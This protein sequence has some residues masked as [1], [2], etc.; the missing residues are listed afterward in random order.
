MAKYSEAQKRANQKYQNK[1]KETRRKTTIDNY[2]RSA[3]LFIRNHST[4]NDLR[5]L[6]RLISERK[7]ELQDNNMKHLD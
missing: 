4:L 5:E 1:D 3:R 6:E 2:K 7:N